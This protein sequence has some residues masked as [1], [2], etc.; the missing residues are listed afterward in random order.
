MPPEYSLY[1]AKAKLSALIRQ[2]REGRSVV[3]TL[4]GEPVA[5]LTP[6]DRSN[7]PVSLRQ[8][9]DELAKQGELVRPHGSTTPIRVG[10][11]K[12]GALRRFLAERD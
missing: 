3:I 8:R 9:M 7:R 11:A 6:V 2:V 10:K 12:R 4:H 5:Q 1:E